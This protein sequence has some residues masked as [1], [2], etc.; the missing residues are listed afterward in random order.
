MTER[1]KKINP[2]ILPEKQKLEE[3]IIEQIEEAELVQIVETLPMPVNNPGVQSD[4]VSNLDKHQVYSRIEKIFQ[5]IK[6]ERKETQE[7]GLLLKKYAAQ[8]G[9]LTKG[10]I[11][12]VKDQF[13]DLLKM[14]GLSIPL[15]MPFSPVIIPLIVKLGLKVGIRILPTS[16]Y[17][18]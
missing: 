4:F 15:I 17:D 14:A 5:A 6:N 10:E 7:L 11:K 13:F 18:D 2:E 12:I 9:N 8:S 1:D 16:F 3:E